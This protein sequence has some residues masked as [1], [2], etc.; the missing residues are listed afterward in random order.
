MIYYADV[1]NNRRSLSTRSD[2]TSAA[3]QRLFNY[4]PK[5]GPL[6]PNRFSLAFVH[7]SMRSHRRT[8]RDTHPVD[9]RLPSFHGQSRLPLKRRRS[10]GSGFKY[11][12]NTNIELAHTISNLISTTN[13][14]PIVIAIVLAFE[15]PLVSNFAVVK[16]CFTTRPKLESSKL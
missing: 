1:S 9:L 16:N 7:K 12:S 13:D 4:H 10:K 14:R 8:N 11:V 6:S 3:G 2:Q 5:R 15:Q